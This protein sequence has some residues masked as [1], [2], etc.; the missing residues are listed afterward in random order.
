VQTNLLGIFGDQL[1]LVSDDLPQPT[2]KLYKY[3]A[4][5]K[6]GQS[7]IYAGFPKK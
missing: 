6:N 2:N 4:T 7:Y 3:N 1:D 5:T